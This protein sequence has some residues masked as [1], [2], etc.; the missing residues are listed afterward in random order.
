MRT[1]FRQVTLQTSEDSL[2]AKLSRISPKSVRRQ[3]LKNLGRPARTFSAERAQ[4][5]TR[6]NLVQNNSKII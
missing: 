2:H 6:A 5:K 1:Y 3:E 4:K